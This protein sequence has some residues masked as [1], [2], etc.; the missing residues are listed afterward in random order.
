MK[1][2]AVIVTY[3]NRFKFLKQV[4]D[5][6]FKE[7]IDKVIVIDNAS[8][9]NSRKQLR[10]YEKKNKDRL[11]VIYLDENTGSARGYK[12]GLEEAYKCED[13]EFIWLLDDD[14]EPQK[15]SLKLLKKFWNNLN[16]ESK[17]KKIALLSYRP[18]RDIYKEA[19]VSNNSYL[20]LGK[21]D[22]FMGFHIV[23]FPKK[24]LKVLKRKLG[25]HNFKK[26]RSTENG[27]VAVA[28]YGG[29][30]FHKSLLSKIGYPREEFFLY[31]DDH[32]WTY[33]ITKG[34]GKIFVI[35]DSIIKDIDVSWHL[36]EKGNSSFSTILSAKSK[37][38]IYYSVRNRII[39]EK[40]NLVRRPAIYYLNMYIYRLLLK[41]FYL[42][43]NN[44]DI[45][46]V[47]LKIFDKAVRD[48]LEG[49]ID[50]NESFNI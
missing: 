4:I 13:C 18:S 38:R 35:F 7:G 23:D 43:S 49:V 44:K 20:V 6:C 19:V 2:C 3:G 45:S 42:F 27:K 22:S 12:R 24:V 33:R 40:E 47:N 17:E 8:V 28:P 41:L 46:K 14:N 32:E 15:A 25:I 1:V 26:N 21:F 31:T 29:I 39:F 36:K 11:K 37:M 16:E 48:G 5:A 30:F 9:E 34:G 10:E 50:K